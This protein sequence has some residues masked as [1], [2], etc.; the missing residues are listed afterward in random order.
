MI[1]STGEQMTFLAAGSFEMTSEQRSV[2]NVLKHH[3]GKASAIR[4]RDLVR[5]CAL[6]ERKV[7]DIVTSLILVF[8]IRIGSTYS[9]RQPGYF[10]IES[11]EEAEATYEVLRGHALS[12][13]RRA[14]VIRRL[15]FPELLGQ[16][17][18]PDRK[19]D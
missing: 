5:Q 6:P 16:L 13:L 11:A 2:W 12:I 8:H 15:S 1:H 18:I 3:S 4:I 9:G 10:V 19:V 7:R 14:A 17:I